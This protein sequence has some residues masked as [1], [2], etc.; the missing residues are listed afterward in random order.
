VSIRAHAPAASGVY[1][2]SN[3]RQWIYIGVADDIRQALMEHLSKSGTA[4]KSHVPTGFSYE[5]CDPQMRTGRFDRLVVQ[6]DPVCNRE[7]QR[8]NGR[9]AQ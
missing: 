6:Y 7:R 8:V 9:T 4:I 1:G 2:I 3:A 5:M